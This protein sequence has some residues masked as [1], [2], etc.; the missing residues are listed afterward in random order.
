MW[1]VSGCKGCS[2]SYRMGSVAW[3]TWPLTFHSRFVNGHML[4]LGI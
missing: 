2:L 3:S 1:L 4:A